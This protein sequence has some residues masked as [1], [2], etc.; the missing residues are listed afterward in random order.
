MNKRSWSGIIA[1][2]IFVTCVGLGTMGPARMV[3]NSFT[4]AA[5]D[6]E[7]IFLLAGGIV[8]CLIGFIGMGGVMGWIP[9]F[10]QES[11]VATS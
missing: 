9:G 4:Y 3:A 10:I 2:G 5:P 7:V 8:T 11:R 6:Q 1:W